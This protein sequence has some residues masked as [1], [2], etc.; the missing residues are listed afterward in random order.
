MTFWIHAST[1]FTC[2]VGSSMPELIICSPEDYYSDSMK[3]YI[4]RNRVDPRNRWIFNI[5]DGHVPLNE[6]VLKTCPA[7]TL[8]RDVHG[9]DGKW[10]VVLHDR[11]LQCLRDFRGE[12]TNLLISLR[13]DVMEALQ[14]HYNTTAVSSFVFFMHY[15][16]STFQ[17]HIH[18]HCP[19]ILRP[20]TEDESHIPRIVYSRRQNLQHILRNLLKDDL[21]YSKCLFLV[22]GCR[23]TKSMGPYSCTSLNTMDTATALPRPPSRPARSAPESSS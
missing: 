12:H 20:Y 8:C 5:I 22:D 18:V 19:Q 14:R 7:W 13:Q 9:V 6:I 17:A 21:Y 4:F 3:E 1:V 2:R 23:L 15:F 10:L 16:P 11:T